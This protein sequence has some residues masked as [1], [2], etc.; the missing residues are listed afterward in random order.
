MTHILILVFCILSVEIFIK[1]NFLFI[2]GISST[3]IQK[4]VY[5]I[6][7]RKISDHWKEKILPVYALRIMRYSLQI[8]IILL[9]IITLFIT[10]NYFYNNFGNLMFS[11]IGIVESLVFSTGYLF[12]RKSIIK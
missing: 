7:S 3:V 4:V 12:L 1:S 8:L 2:F 6:F 9:F 11:L 10:V 5:V